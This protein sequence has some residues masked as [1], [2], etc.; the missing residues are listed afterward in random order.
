M[1][2]NQGKEPPN[3]FLTNQRPQGVRDQTGLEIQESNDGGA[4][5]TK[6]ASPGTVNA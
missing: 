4:T 1:T 6:F 5:W 2:R 3:A